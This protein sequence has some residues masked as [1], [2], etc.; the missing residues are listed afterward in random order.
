MVQPQAQLGNGNFTL[1]NVKYGGPLFSGDA[2]DKDGD[3]ELWV[4][5]I[6]NYQKA[7][8]EVWKLERKENGYYTLKN[9]KYNGTLF[10][11]DAVDKF[12]DHRAYIAYDKCKNPDKESWEIKHEG[13]GEYKF[14]N[15]LWGGP[16]FCGDGKDNVGDHGVWIATQRSYNSNGKELWRLMAVDE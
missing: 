14:F 12:G 4:S 9:G 16:L 7:N 10:C 11:G 13:N 1:H 5:P 3:H 8:K 6:A 15:V 2:A